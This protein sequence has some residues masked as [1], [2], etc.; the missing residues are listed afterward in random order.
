MGSTLEAHRMKTVGVR[1]QHPDWSAEGVRQ[2]VRQLFS[3]ARP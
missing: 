1:S 3:N 2:E